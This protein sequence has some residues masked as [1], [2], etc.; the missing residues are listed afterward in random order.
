MMFCFFRISFG[1]AGFAT[2]SGIY[3]INT[4]VTPDVSL[5]SVGDGM[6]IG[7]GYYHDA[8]AVATSTVFVVTYNPDTGGIYFTP[9]TNGAISATSP[10]VP[11]QGD[12]FVGYFML[13]V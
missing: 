13:P 6:P 4:P 12:S 1:A 7:K 9:P 10:F 8:S 2:G 3:G 11:A 5:D